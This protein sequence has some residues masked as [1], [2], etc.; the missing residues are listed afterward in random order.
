MVFLLGAGGLLLAQPEASGYTFSDLYYFLSQGISAEEGG[1][2]LEPPEGT[3]PGVNPF[4]SLDEI[5]DEMAFEFAKVNL[6]SWQ[7]PAGVSYWSTDTGA[8]GVRVGIGRFSDKGETVIDNS[9]GLMWARHGGNA[10]CANG[11]AM[12]WTQAVNWGNNLVFAGYN[13]WRLPSLDE[14]L[15][16]SEPLAHDLQAGP[17]VAPGQNVRSYW[18]STMSH[19][20]SR[21]CTVYFGPRYYGWDNPYQSQS[22]YVRAVRTN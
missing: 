10:G 9:T 11:S 1:H 5:Y 18:S 6:Q 20:A 2:G 21:P 16:L 4:V 17:A 19:A 13:D 8:W 15:S 22:W 14:L 3:D 12:N 7:V